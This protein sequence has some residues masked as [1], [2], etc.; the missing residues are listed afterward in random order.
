EH[1]DQIRMGRELS[2][3]VRDLPIEIDLEAARL[4][5]YDRDTVV[6]PAPQ[7]SGRPATLAAGT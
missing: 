2:L 1:V 6:R 7:P 4:G 3:I 5:D